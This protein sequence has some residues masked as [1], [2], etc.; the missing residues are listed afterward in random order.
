MKIVVLCVT[1]PYKGIYT[2]LREYCH[3][4]ESQ[5]YFCREEFPSWVL[6]DE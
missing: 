3:V 6:K 2:V 4:W 1:Y 5:G